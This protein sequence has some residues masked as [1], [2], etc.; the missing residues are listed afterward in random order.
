MERTQYETEGFY[1]LLTLYMIDPED[2]PPM[3][4]KP[5]YNSSEGESS[6]GAELRKPIKMK[7][8]VKDSK[9]LPS[10]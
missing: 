9:E 6:E 3:S 7:L 2:F 5:S 8:K 4:F 1:Q 10:D